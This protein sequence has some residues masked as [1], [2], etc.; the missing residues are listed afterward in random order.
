MLNSGVSQR[1]EAVMK[2]GEI[3]SRFIDEMKKTNYGLAE[4]ARMGGLSQEQCNLVDEFYK[5]GNAKCLRGKEA[6]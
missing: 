3:E 5:K 6:G 2:I 4:S 1:K